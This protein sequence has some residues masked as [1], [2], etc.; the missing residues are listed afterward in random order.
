MSGRKQFDVDQAVDQSMLTFWASG[1]TQT[2]LDQLT[3][4]TG[5]GRGSLY[6]TFGGKNGLFLAALRRYGQVYGQQYDAALARHPHDAV[7]ASRAYL[8]VVLARIADPAVPDGCLVAMAAAQAG[9]LE[10]DAHSA[11]TAAL[12]EQRDRL[13][14]ALTRRGV[15][16]HQAHDL[17]CFLVA[18]TQSLALLS[19]AGTT[20]AEL[21][22]IVDISVGATSI[23][24]QTSGG[25][26]AL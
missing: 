6:A 9:T 13:R 1:Y 21:G 25:S 16:T 20:A 2:S 14:H 12:D 4:V 22:A 11:V 17:A 19:R 15:H 26:T 8:Q 5:L 24:L 18:V 10:D 3:T 7:A 23:A